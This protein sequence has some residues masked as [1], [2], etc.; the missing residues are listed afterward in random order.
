MGDLEPGTSVKSLRTDRDD[1]R[2]AYDY[3]GVVQRR[4]PNEKYES[5][6]VSWDYYPTE[7]MMRDEFDLVTEEDKLYLLA[8]EVMET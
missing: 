5:Y 3:S 2:Q 7:I 4:V 1:L 8:L 6:S